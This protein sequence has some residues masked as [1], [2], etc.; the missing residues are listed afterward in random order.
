MILT[1][2]ILP[3]HPLTLILNVNHLFLY[4]SVLFLGLN[5]DNKLKF[6]IHI[7]LASKKVYK[8]IGILYKLKQ[9]LFSTTYLF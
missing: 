8:S 2:S 9:M 1:N 7:N 3:D 5:L 6:G 4:E